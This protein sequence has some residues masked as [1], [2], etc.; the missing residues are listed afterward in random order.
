MI[1][2]PELFARA[3]EWSGSLIR[4]PNGSPRSTDFDSVAQHHDKLIIIEAKKLI[5][6]EL[7]LPF[8]QFRTLQEF[9]NQLKQPHF[10]IAGTHSYKMSNPEDL[11][12]HLDFGRIISGKIPYQRTQHGGIVLNVKNMIVSKR[13][14]F[15]IMCKKIL[16]SKI[17]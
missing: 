6:D 5:H 11:M 3:S 8:G 14:E 12:C 10:F 1:R 16:D 15:S 2:N 17:D 9:H 7:Y 4:Y 13:K